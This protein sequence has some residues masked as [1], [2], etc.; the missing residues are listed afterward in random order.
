M[1]RPLCWGIECLGV[2][3]AV[4]AIGCGG[5]SY[6][7][8]TS[9]GGSGA[10]SVMNGQYAF[11]ASGFGGAV[12]GS[13]TTDGQGHITGGVEDVHAPNF[14][15]A[16]ND[17]TIT[18]GSY[19]ISSN[20]TGTFTYKDSNSNT[21][22]FAVALGTISNGVATRGT[23][24]EFDNN[25]LTGNQPLET[26]G[27]IALQDASA[28]STSALSGAYVFGFDGFNAAQQPNATIGT[29]TA[30]D[31]SFTN[32][33]FDQNSAATTGGARITSDAS[34]TANFS[35]D[36]NSRGVVNVTGINEVGTF[37][38]YAVSAGEW[39]AID[40]A[41]DTDDYT[42]VILQQTGG[43]LTSSSINGAMVLQDQ[44]ASAISAPAAMLGLFTSG[45]NG[46]AS[47]SYDENNDGTVSL[48]Q[49]SSSSISFTSG[50]NGRFTISPAPQGA[51]SE[52]VGYMVAP[53]Q[54]VFTSTNTLGPDFG[55][56]EPQSGGP[57]SSSS[58]NGSFFFG[59]LAINS[60][61]VDP[62]GNTPPLV[63]DSGVVTLSSGS[64]SGTEA[65]NSSGTLNSGS[66][67]ISGTYTVASDGRVT[68][69]ANVLL[70]IV[71]P[72]KVYLLDTTPSTSGY[73]PTIQVFQ[74]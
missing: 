4:F 43:P 24:I 14:A 50:A 73:N 18:S 56:F 70:Y 59:S 6:N 52:L 60:V 5:G 49:S 13:I 19:S 25:Q 21:F 3:L 45:G 42:G 29:F 64:L 1:K 51:S 55:T 46:S 65:Q 34:F 69:N 62:T 17:L 41:T 71:S 36:S 12:A 40:V 57:F 54:A 58:A 31:G 10:D 38:I 23:I 30:S 11:V 16:G 47:L 72:T 20:N 15:G 48:S 35:V 32:A 7:S 8:S 28:F 37:A 33:L 27:Q 2:L 74:Q 68:T 44:F 26:T 53:N 66:G 67:S 39:F 22:T 9:G 61:P 63:F